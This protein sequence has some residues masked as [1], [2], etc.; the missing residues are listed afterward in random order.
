MVLKGMLTENNKNTEE[1]N[2]NNKNNKEGG[3]KAWPQSIHAP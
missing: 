3:I 2:N 1:D